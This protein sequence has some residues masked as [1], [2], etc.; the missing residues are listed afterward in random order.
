[1]SNAICTTSR[2]KPVR[3]HCITGPSSSADGTAGRCSPRDSSCWPSSAASSGRRGDCV[4]PS[5]RGS[6]KL[7]AAVDAQAK[8]RDAEVEKRRPSAAAREEQ[9]GKR[10]RGQGARKPSR[11]AAE[12]RSRARR[13][14]K[15]L[16]RAEGL[17]L[18]AQSSAELHTDPSLGL[19]LAIEAARP[20]PSKEA[21]EAFVAALEAC[22]EERTTTRPRREVLSAHSPPTASRS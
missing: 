11:R 17:R 9:A 6:P 21:N 14:D 16:V 19:L 3:R 12:G 7:E 10:R 1:M 8:E 13:E 15:V 2:W 20:A 18:T 4:G 22:H 5:R